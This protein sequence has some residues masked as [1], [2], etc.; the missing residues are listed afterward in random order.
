MVNTF[1]P[2]PGYDKTAKALDNKRLGKQ[3]V[4]ALQILKANLGMTVGWRN[5]PAAIM[6]R[7]HE[8]D[9]CRYALAICEEWKARGYTDTVSAQI[10]EIAK[11]LPPESFR[12]PWWNGNESFHQSHQSNLVRKDPTHY[13]FPVVDDLPYLWPKQEIGKLQT[14]EQAHEEKRLL[15]QH[16]KEPRKKR[17]LASKSRDDGTR[18]AGAADSPRVSVVKRSTS[19]KMG[20]LPGK[21]KSS[22]LGRI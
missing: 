7:G 10:D 4:E 17:G 13:T 15:L 19:Q 21:S 1:L 12:R 5:H 18:T 2:W 8:G 16:S 14:K 9:L 11:D 20:R 22:E 3:R 6:W